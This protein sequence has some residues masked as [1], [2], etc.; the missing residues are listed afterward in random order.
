MYPETSAEL[1]AGLKIIYPWLLYLYVQPYDDIEENIIMNV[2]S[3]N[4]LFQIFNH[5]K[6]SNNIS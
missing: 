4:I 3:K 2:P 1:V 5:E 6:L